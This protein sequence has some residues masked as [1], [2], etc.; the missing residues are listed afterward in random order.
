MRKDLSRS[1]PG[2]VDRMPASRRSSFLSPWSDDFWEPTRWFDDFFGRDMS[3]FPMDSRFLSPA[4]DIEESND[5]YVVSADLPGIKKEDISIECHE[6]QLT[7]SA[8]RKYESNE[9]K[10][11]DRRERFYGTYQRSFT[12]PSGIDPDKIEASYEGGVLNIRIPKG[13]QQK[14]RRIEIGDTKK[15]KDI[16]VQNEE[17][18]NNAKH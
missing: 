11:H 13:E 9:G 6:N 17:Q 1:Q 10:K 7:I 12:L 4:I 8:E 15:N 5:E 16:P 18:K 2:Q 3:N 14:A